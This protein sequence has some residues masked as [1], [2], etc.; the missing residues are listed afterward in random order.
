M[1][2]LVE[3]EF[4]VLFGDGAAAAGSAIGAGA[5]GLTSHCLR[6]AP[7]AVER[8]A[9]RSGVTLSKVVPSTVAAVSTPDI[10]ADPTPQ[11]RMS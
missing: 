5:I 9:S 7:S 3:E 10:S 2:E 1:I 6:R 4:A 8:P 11:N